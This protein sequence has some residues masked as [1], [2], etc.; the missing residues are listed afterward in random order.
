LQ[1]ELANESF[2]LNGRDFEVKIFEE[3]LAVRANILIFGGG[4]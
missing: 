3:K 1:L 4:T 2:N